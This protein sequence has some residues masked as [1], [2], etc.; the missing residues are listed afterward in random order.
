[1]WGAM[2]A[3]LSGAALSHRAAVDSGAF[4]R[5]AKPPGLDIWWRADR[6]GICVTKYLHIVDYFYQ[7]MLILC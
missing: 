1:M 2:W 6:L 3:I 4:L 5:D 7:G